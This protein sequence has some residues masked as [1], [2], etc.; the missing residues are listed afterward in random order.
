MPEL[1]EVEIA[2][3]NLRRWTKGRRLRAVEADRKSILEGEGGLELGDLAGARFSGVDRVGKNLLLTLE[4]GRSKMG[5]WS[6]LGMTGK[7]LR[8]ASEAE[9]PR[10]SHVRLALDGG[11]T[12][13]YCDMR[14]F[15]RL[16]VV[17]GARFE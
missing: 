10:F 2:A 15:G 12:L 17:P 16:R 11:A 5:L 1:P 13:H 6:H 8:R 9:A 7:W 3:R 14:L 4:R